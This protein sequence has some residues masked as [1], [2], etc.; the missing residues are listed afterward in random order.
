MGTVR[1]AHTLVSINLPTYHALLYLLV[2]VFLAITMA[3]MH[4]IFQSVK[5]NGLPLEAFAWKLNELIQPGHS[6]VVGLSCNNY[7]CGGYMYNHCR[8]ITGNYSIW[9]AAATHGVLVSIYGANCRFVKWWTIGV[10][11]KARLYPAGNQSEINR[12]SACVVRLVTKHQP[13]R[14][15][16]SAPHTGLA[17]RHPKKFLTTCF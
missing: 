8:I 15:R 12:S 10:S 2:N 7:S 6:Y 16:H 14:S 4:H 17:R 3:L 1:L 13:W 5:K 9:H 11:I